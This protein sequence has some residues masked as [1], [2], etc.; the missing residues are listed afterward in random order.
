LRCRRHASSAPPAP[1]LLRYQPTAAL[2]RWAF[3]AKIAEA[4]G[5]DV[6]PGTI[7]KFRAAGDAETAALLEDTVYPEEVRPQAP[8]CYDMHVYH[9]WGSVAAV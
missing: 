9:V 7:Q 5:L 1:R 2:A 6:L 4:R 3:A 8:L